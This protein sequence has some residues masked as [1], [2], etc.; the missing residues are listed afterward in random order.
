MK[1]SFLV[2]YYNQEQY[3]HQS[4]DSILAIKKPAEWEILVGDDGSSDKTVEI[5]N[6]YVSND[7]EHIRLYVMP[8][9]AGRQYNAIRRASAN[10]LNLLEHC[11]GDCFCTLD[12]D[13]FYADARFALE[14]VDVLRSHDDV[15]VV[16][17]GYWYF[18]DGKF[19]KEELLPPGTGPRVDTGYYIR[20]FYLHAGAAVHRFSWEKNRIGY[21]KELGC[22]DDN[23]IM[24][25]S[26]N[27]GNMYY[28]D[29]CVYAYRQTGASIYTR[30][31]SAEKAVLNTVAYDIG[32][33]IIDQ[34]G[35]LLERYKRPILM[36]YIWR[37]RIQDMLGDSKYRRYVEE[38]KKIENAI[39]YKLLTYK[40]LDRSEK[41]EIRALA[42]Q[43]LLKAICKLPRKLFFSMQKMSASA[44]KFKRGK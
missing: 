3:V 16:S 17:F 33:L 43:A 41:K 14:A 36:M 7:P 21:L 5:V 31:Q 2:T 44:N 34:S 28:I 29:R 20:N 12:G 25:N 42:L 6:E 10:R 30:M 13:D 11:S 38:C 37:N 9:E 22:F 4:M 15:S 32:R 1:I 23:D 24:M 18:R 27:Y 39:S 8:R 19:E 40:E 26:L 35:C